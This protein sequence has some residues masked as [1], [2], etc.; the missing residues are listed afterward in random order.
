MKPYTNAEIAQALQANLRTTLDSR[1][2]VEVKD[3]N[4]IILSHD[5]KHDKEYK[6]GNM[7]GFNVT[8]QYD[9]ELNH[10]KSANLY[11]IDTLKRT[12]QDQFISLNNMGALNINEMLLQSVKNKDLEAV[13]SCLI[14]QNRDNGIEFVNA[15]NEF[16]ETALFNA[17][18]NEDA[19]M[20]KLLINN[21]ADVNVKNKSGNTPL[22]IIAT[23]YTTSQNKINIANMLVE[24]GADIYLKDNSGKAV[25]DMVKTEEMKNIFNKAIQKT[26]AKE[27]IKEKSKVKEK[28]KSKSN[29]Y[30]MGM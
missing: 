9:E 1:Y 7:F 29:D 5:N 28:S 4:S 25:F 15:K 26:Y 12:I 8:L 22:M 23:Q 6:F 18:I 10:N 20:T 17:V 13:K 11:K 27:P 14:W 16:G 21:G 2:S 19:E 30:G 24:N 3:D